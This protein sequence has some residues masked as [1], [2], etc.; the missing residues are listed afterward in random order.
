MSSPIVLMFT[1][2]KALALA[3]GIMAAL[4]LSVAAQTNVAGQWTVTS[5]TDQGEQPPLDD[6]VAAGR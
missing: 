3:L 2:G 5:S 4:S 1:R 6:D